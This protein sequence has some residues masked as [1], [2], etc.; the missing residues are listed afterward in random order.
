MSK[1]WTVLKQAFSGWSIHNVSRLAAALSYYTIFSLAPLLVIAIAIAAFFFGAKAVSGEVGQTLQGTIG[2]NGAQA[3]QGMMASASRPQGGG[4]LLATI[5]GIVMLVVG[6]SGVFME[7][8]ASLNTIWEVELRP[9]RGIWGIVRD[10]VLSLTMVMGTAFL[11]L[12]SLIISAALTAIGNFMPE[13]LPGGQT[14]WMVINSVVSFL[15]ISFMFALIFK[16]VPDIKIRWRDVLVGALVTGAL[17]TLGKT[18]LGLYLG[19][20]AVASTYGAAGSLAIV[21]LWVYYVSQIFFFGA[22]FTRAYTQVI[23]SGAQPD[24]SAV[25][26]KADRR[27]AEEKTEEIRTGSATAQTTRREETPSQRRRREE[28]TR[29]P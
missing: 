17:F 2:Q 20:S 27:E 1:T 25:T 19:R 16:Y 7:L 3:V 24:A 29:R 10:R 5:L 13:L 23:G 12:V 8:Q 9:N 26:V 14:V 11:L 22:E 21:L 15:V 4:G 18:L 6:A 28:E